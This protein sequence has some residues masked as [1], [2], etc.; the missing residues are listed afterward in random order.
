MG[1]LRLLEGMR[2]PFLDTIFQW[3]TYFGEE[4]LFIVIALI[5]YWCLDK[6]R[7][8]FL[9]FVCFT[10]TVINQFLKLLCAVPRP[11]VRD[12]SFTIVESAREGAGGY[13][14]PSGHT[15]SVADT[16]L[17]IA[18]FSKKNWLRAACVALV[19]LTAFSRMYLGVH[20]P[21]D[22]FVSL[23]VAL[24]L[25]FAGY[26]LFMRAQEN[27]RRMAVLLG[28]LIA[29]AAAFVLY[30]E[31]APATERTIAEFA[32]AG[33][34][35]AWQMLGLA[36]GFALVWWLD[37]RYIRFDTKA[38]LLG[39]ALKLA[40]GFGLIL[41]VRLLLKAPLLALTGGHESAH[42]IRYFL[43]L[44]VGGGLWPLTFP[45]FAKLGK[46]QAPAEA[47]AA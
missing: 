30:A 21:A 36:L 6:Q 19:A 45:W 46:K 7:G 5:F 33:V 39:Q 25:V 27:K 35:N 14:F 29:A 41:A 13:S 4:T 42:G 37:E 22:V 2:N 9:L 12:P 15:Q 1:F 43:M 26:P 11:W 31:L 24:V 38:P 44:A 3:I 40:L 34:K 18:R 20:T 10:G 28:V 23:G 32:A 16:F 17:G 47:E 8:Y